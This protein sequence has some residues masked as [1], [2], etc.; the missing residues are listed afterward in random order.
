M[1]PSISP[2]P[3]PHRHPGIRMDG[4]DHHLH[5][6]RDQLALCYHEQLVWNAPP[7]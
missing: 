4:L 6:I 2:L 3:R 7:C 5:P 1:V